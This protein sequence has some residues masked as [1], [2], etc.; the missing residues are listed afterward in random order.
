MGLKKLTEEY[1]SLSRIPDRVLQEEGYRRERRPNGIVRVIKKENYNRKKEKKRTLVGLL[2]GP[3][4]AH[5]YANDRTFIKQ[6]DED[7]SQVRTKTLEK[8]VKHAQTLRDAGVP[9]IFTVENEGYNVWEDRKGNIHRTFPE[10]DYMANLF[11]TSLQR[12]K[13]EKRVYGIR[14]RYTDPTSVA[15]L[16]IFATYGFPTHSIRGEEAAELVRREL[17]NHTERL[18]RNNFQNDETMEMVME[19][20]GTVYDNIRD[21]MRQW[22]E[23]IDIQEVPDRP[24]LSP[25]DVQTRRFW[26]VFTDSNTADELIE[27]YQDRLALQV[28]G[29]GKNNARTVLRTLNNVRYSSIKDAAF[30]QGLEKKVAKQAIRMA[31]PDPLDVIAYTPENMHNDLTRPSSLTKRKQRLYEKALIE[32]KQESKDRLNVPYKATL[33]QSVDKRNIESFM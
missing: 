17:Q 24:S 18:F 5:L 16:K 31:N 3:L 23:K 14:P 8:A 11:S 22:R 25:K 27:R 21:T 26:Y 4:K 1:S 9:P 29:S 30:I 20:I 28:A 13:T 33:P 12:L 10:L 7:P 19:N 32:V 6:H 15:N 2:K